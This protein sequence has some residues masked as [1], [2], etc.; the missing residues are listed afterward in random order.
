MLCHHIIHTTPAATSQSISN[1]LPYYDI[2]TL[3]TYLGWRLHTSPAAWSTP[4]Q[5]CHHRV[6]GWMN[7]W[8]HKYTTAIAML[9]P[10]LYL[11]ISIILNRAHTL[12]F[13]LTSQQQQEDRT[14]WWPR[15]RSQRQYVLPDSRKECLLQIEEVVGGRGWGLI[16]DDNTVCLLLYTHNII[17]SLLPHISS[18]QHN[19][20]TYIQYKYV[21]F[22]KYL[23]VGKPLMS[24][25]LPI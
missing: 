6:D 15:S 22:L 20:G 7:R 10:Y 3:S 21:P 17:S 5:S 9:Q 13:S 24:Y 16:W 23:I 11:S 12:S 1:T 14:S 2:I 25:F 18:S 8:M 4:P 19:K